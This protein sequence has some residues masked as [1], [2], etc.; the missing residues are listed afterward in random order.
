MCAS[1]GA[2]K[3]HDT[4]WLSKIPKTASK[5]IGPPETDLQMMYEVKAVRRLRAIQG[6]VL[7]SE[8]LDKQTSLRSDRLCSVKT[9]TNRCEDPH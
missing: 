3:E 2:M 7:L 6:D 5:L 4:A 1:L 9:H 8:V